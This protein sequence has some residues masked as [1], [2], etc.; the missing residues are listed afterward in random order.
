MGEQGR[1]RTQPLLKSKGQLHPLGVACSWVNGLTFLSPELLWPR[2]S[3]VHH[4]VIP[5]LPQC[6]VVTERC[7]SYQKS[8]ISAALS[9]KCAHRTHSS[10][11]NVSGSAVCHSWAGLSICL[12]WLKT[13]DFEAS[14]D[15]GTTKRSVPW[16]PKQHVEDSHQPARNTWVLVF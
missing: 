7:L 15:G 11:R 14:E 12:H 9:L 8:L 3:F 2:T 6:G 13:K 10:Q 1:G 16:V 5:P 4:R